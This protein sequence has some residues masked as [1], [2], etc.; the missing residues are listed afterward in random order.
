MSDERM[1][2]TNHHMLDARVGTGVAL[3]YLDDPCIGWT[4][5]ISDFIGSAL[6]HEN[7]I[8][9]AIIIPGTS[10]ITPAFDRLTEAAGT[11]VLVEDGDGHR[12]LR[13]G[14]WAPSIAQFFEG[15]PRSQFTV[16]QQFLHPSHEPALVPTLMLS[17]SI[18]HP[19]RRTTKLGRATEIITET[20]LPGPSTTLSWGRYEPVGAPWDRGRLT[21]LAR[22]LMPE[23]HFNLAAH[24]QTGTLSGTMTVA[25][26]SNG[27]E[28]YIEVSVTT[29]NL[30]PAQQIDMVNT[31]LDTIAEQT[32]PQFVLAVRV[33]ALED[34]SLP[35]SLRQPPVP[36]AVLIG[37][38]GIRQLGVDARD[39]ARQHGG[40]TY[41]SGRR[42]GLIVPV[43]TTQSDWS[44][45]A[46]LV[47]TLDGEA[48]NIARVLEDPADGSGAGR[49]H[50]S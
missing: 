49:T 45:L 35:T 46:S 31:L 20:L 40:R 19:A 22:E 5:Y 30:A 26:T 13:S 34:T 25:R 9:P 15:A 17:A 41:G 32:K 42:Q 21:A 23:I 27:L 50:A 37:S 11:V 36:L 18:Y 28:E 10:H 44:A 12:E 2:D 4:E 14:M 47:A 6:R 29:P 3:T 39:V 8:T 33:Q 43:E 1:P 16:S 24:S 38:A 7:E 48:G